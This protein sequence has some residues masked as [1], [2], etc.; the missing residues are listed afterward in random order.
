MCCCDTKPKGD[1]MFLSKKNSKSNENCSDF[2]NILPLLPLRDIVIFPHMIMP[3]FVGRPSSVKAVN[4]AMKKTDNKIVLCAQKSATI[5]NPQT[6]DIYDTGTLGEILQ[7]LKLPDGTIKVLIEAICRVKIIEHLN[8][9]NEYF[10]VCCQ[11]AEDETGDNPKLEALTRNI[12]GKFEEYNQ[13]SNKI[14]PD[15]IATIKAIEEPGRLA[16]VIVYNLSLKVK[17]T[18]D[19]LD[20][21]D[22]KVR[23]EKL[24][25]ILNSEIAVFNV[26]KNLRG[27]VKKQ[28]ESTQK[29]YYLNEQMK[30]IKKELGNIDG[31]NSDI[32][33][34]ENKIKN[35]K[36]HKEAEES[37]LKE[38]KKLE[39][40]PAMSAEATVVRN[41]ID[42]FISLPWEKKSRDNLDLKKA[43]IILNNDHYGLEKAKERILEYLAVRR[44]VK[45]MK[46][47]ILCF[48]GPPGG[49]KTS[50]AAS[51]AR[52]AGRKF[53]RISLGGIRDE[54]EIR[55]HRR[56]YI[57]ALPGRIIQAMKKAGTKNPVMLLDEID[58][59]STDFR[60][61]PSS[62]LLEVL[63]PEQNNTFSDHYLEVEYDL[64]EVMFITTANVTHKI[65]QPLLD[66]MEVI[67]LAGYTEL[68]KIK[69]AQIFLA[70]KQ[71]KDHGLKDENI[72]FSE[73]AIKMII[74]RYTREAGVRN[75]E[76]EVAS[77]CRKIARKVVES[78]NKNI[79]IKIEAKDIPKYLD[80]PK[81]KELKK[82]RKD[83]VGI[84]TG[85]AWT[86]AGGTILTIEATV[87]EG[88]GKLNL[89]GQLGDVMQ[90]SART[91]LSYVRSKA[92]SLGLPPNFYQ[93]MEI[94]IHVPEGSIPKDGPSAGVTMAVVL[95]SALSNMP[96]K[97]D[98]AMTGE[99]TLRGKVLAIGGLKEK[100]LAAHRAGIST[101]ILP[102]ENENDLKDI[103]DV[104]SND[105][106]FILVENVEEVLKKAL[107]G[108]PVRS[109][110]VSN[111]ILAREEE[112]LLPT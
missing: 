6:S 65:P 70:P 72:I 4:T 82:E 37:A 105:I 55:G 27:R 8:T 73:N 7:I 98:L 30:A 24:Y 18:Q 5:D 43:E 3:L 46:G 45:K 101:I 76:R 60:G 14:P 91:A 28:I 49:G 33:E 75:L 12:L 42:W 35:A 58:K 71:L 78:D 83:E 89:T 22:P 63:D 52:S 68:E 41:Y 103:P 23:L 40:M 48:V 77:I 88:K 64:S 92:K 111:H 99:I 11:Y 81:Y 61:D 86:E 25:D 21:I 108:Y 13:I 107:V 50:L 53:V 100:V 96:F 67:R 87:M 47:P 9:T 31:R 38:L 54:A 1:S 106:H 104:V 66:R 102:K 56:T 36:M 94:H 15:M 16:D 2:N 95:A 85:L 57:G 17:D 26:E 39:M 51:I 62:A 93:E 110:N 44:L 32:K 69:I 112:V 19:I 59:M 90:E 29:E 10:E 34:L 97:N 20:S 84:A 74:N 109:K 80:I 79:K